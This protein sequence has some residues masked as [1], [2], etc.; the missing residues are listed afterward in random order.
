MS[1]KTGLI[2]PV[3]LSGGSGTRLWPLSRKA[4]PKQLLAL[5]GPNTMIQDTVARARG[6]YFSAPLI[7]SNQDHRF[8]VAEQ[9]RAQGI[10]GARII[11]EPIGRN[12]APAAAIA[13]FACAS[14]PARSIA[15]QPSSSTTI[16]PNCAPTATVRGK[17]FWI[18]C[19][20]FIHSEEC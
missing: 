10:E 9:L 2:V 5:V 16:T 11:L 17:S 19:P 7:I 15:R 1:Q 12:T 18:S 3:I 20:G 6:D 4:M 14:D 13:V 8:V